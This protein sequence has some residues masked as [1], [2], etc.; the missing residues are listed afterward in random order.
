[1]RKTNKG[2]ATTYLTGVFAWIA[3]AVLI[4]MIWGRDLAPPGDLSR[5]TAD[6]FR[7]PPGKLGGVTDWPATVPA[8]LS[9]LGSALLDAGYARPIAASMVPGALLFAGVMAHRRASWWTLADVP[10]GCVFGLGVGIILNQWVLPSGMSSV[11]APGALLLAGGAF[12]QMFP[13]SI[14]DTEVLRGPEIVPVVSNSR[15]VI[16]KAIK[17]GAVIFAGVLVEFK[18]EVGHFLTLGKTGAGKS[19]AQRQTMSTA[20]ARGDQAVV[21]DPDGGAMAL[22]WRPGDALLNPFDARS[23]KWDIL[24]E[25]SKPSDYA[26][27]AVCLLPAASGSPEHAQWTAWARDV[28]AA[29]LKRWHQEELGSSDEFLRVMATASTAKLGQLCEGTAA[30]RY[31]APGGEKML[32]GMLSGITPLLGDL[33]NVTSMPGQPFSV[34][35]WMRGGKGTLWLPYQADQVAALARLVSCWMRLGLE[36]VQTWPDS[37]TRRVWFVIDELDAIGRIEGLKGGLVRLRKKGGCIVMGTQSTAQVELIY[38]PEDARTMVEQCNTQLI[39][40]CGASGA[41]GGTARFGSDLIGDREVA[42]EEVSTGLTEGQHTSSSLSSHVRRQMERAV[43][44]SEIGDLPD[45]TGYLK[46]PG[47]PWVRVA[48]QWADYPARVAAFAP[49]VLDEAGGS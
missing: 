4:W 45:N 27:L 6:L 12:P 29:C 38:G 23:G 7:L 9:A 22:F 16:E 48:Y 26:H 13:P 3:S 35:R 47:Q 33:E 24:G 44:A 31:F 10:L 28:F 39:L 20:M 30:Q 15:K 1:M 14:P 37:D 41:G 36:E 8:H 49:A 32:A 34:R 19:V 46:R 40:R 42:R 17:R 18:A 25:I 43:L 21:A 2:Y 5:V 11:L